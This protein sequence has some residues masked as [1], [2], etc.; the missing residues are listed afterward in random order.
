MA[1]RNGELEHPEVWPPVGTASYDASAGAFAY[2]DRMVNCEQD[3]CDVWDDPE[4]GV[5][6]FPHD[7]EPHDHEGCACDHRT[8]P[9]HCWQCREETA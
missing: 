4:S 7:R 5:W 1:D 6:H 3:G 9:E 2:L 8:C